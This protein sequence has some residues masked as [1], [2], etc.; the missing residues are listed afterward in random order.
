MAPPSV[1]SLSTQ[2]PP[3]PLNHNP[4]TCYL[5]FSHN[6]SFLGYPTDEICLICRSRVHR[7][8]PRSQRAT[9]AVVRGYTCLRL[10]GGVG[11]FSKVSADRGFGNMMEEEGSRTTP[12]SA[13]R[14]VYAPPFLNG[15]AGYGLFLTIVKISTLHFVFYMRCCCIFWFC[16]MTLALVT[17]SS[18]DLFVFSWWRMFLVIE[19]LSLGRAMI[20]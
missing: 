16:F 12:S 4:L 8:H 11:F 13:A 9:Q 19:E 10:Y 7:Y 5:E 20:C 17:E 2:M 18:P 15:S 14:E 6:S 1:F 3:S